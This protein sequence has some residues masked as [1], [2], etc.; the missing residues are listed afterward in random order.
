MK[1]DVE[2]SKWERVQKQHMMKDEVKMTDGK[3]EC[4]TAY[5][6]ARKHW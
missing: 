4:S 1:L 5:S 6:Y 3:Q 2:R